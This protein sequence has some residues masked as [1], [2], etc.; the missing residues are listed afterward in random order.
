MNGRLPAGI[1][2][3]RDNSQ[4]T[5]RVAR[6]AARVDSA[7]LRGRHRHRPNRYHPSLIRGPLLD[8]R[9]AR[10]RHRGARGR[11]ASQPALRR[12]ED[13]GAPRRPTSEGKPTAAAVSEATHTRAP[14]T[15]PPLGELR[16][17]AQHRVAKGSVRVA[18]AGGSRTE[19]RR[20]A[21]GAREPP[22]ARGRALPRH[23]ARRDRMGSEHPRSARRRAPARLQT[24]AD[25]DHRARRQIGAMKGF[26]PR[27]LTE[28]P[29]LGRSQS[30]R[31]LRQKVS[32]ST[33]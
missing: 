7:A 19:G 29:H 1:V 22:G 9:C 5:A 10:R 23:P 3:S 6:G 4:D 18:R 28:R 14:L 15:G 12:E 30:F 26:F 16:M 24:G 25:C 8:I 32:A 2:P 27:R 31:L 33:G 20:L 11:D 13:C 17:L 21:D